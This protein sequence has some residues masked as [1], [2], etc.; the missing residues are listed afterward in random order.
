MGTMAAKLSL[1]LVALIVA[2][3]ALPVCALASLRR[4][5]MK[6]S[7]KPSACGRRG[8]VFAML[9][10]RR[11]G[12]E[13]V[14][15]AEGGHLFREHFDTGAGDIILSR[16]VHDGRSVTALAHAALPVGT[17]LLAQEN[18]TPQRRLARWNR[19][20]AICVNIFPVVLALFL[21]HP[22]LLRWL[23]VAGVLLCVM[24]A[25]G[26]ILTYPAAAAA[27]ER[28]LRA[29]RENALLPPEEMPEFGAALRTAARRQLAA[30]LL[31]CFWLRWL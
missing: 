13:Q 1:L 3:F 31:D 26:Q 16:A 12:L 24:P 14:G 2:A 8:A 21:L 25:V 18:A 20:T 9:V 11:A 28:V 30:P 27:A 19:A 4:S 10:A 22:A 6:A 23:P 15:V 5:W 7:K 17:L 29:V